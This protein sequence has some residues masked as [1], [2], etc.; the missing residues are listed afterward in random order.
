YR[1]MSTTSS[2]E[3]RFAENL[4]SLVPVGDRGV[5][6]VAFSG[7]VDSTVLLHLLRSARPAFELVAAHFD[8]R[9]REESAEDAAWAARLC[10]EWNVDFELGVAGGPLRGEDAARRARYGFLRE[11]A[12]RRGTGIATAHH[13]DDQAETVLFRILRG[14]G[15]RGLAGIPSRS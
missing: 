4:R 5:L 3:E 15:M 12:A 9:M 8:H 2:F 11:V 10:A 7:G 13:A 1:P 14:T 6:V